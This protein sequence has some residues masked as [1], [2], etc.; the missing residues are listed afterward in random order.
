MRLILLV[1]LCAA[2][3]LADCLVVRVFDPDRLPVAGATAA[4]GS[5]TATS[6]DRGEARLCADDLRNV[7]VRAK[8]FRELR[9]HPAADASSVTAHLEIERRVESAVVV[10]GVIEPT[11]L[12]EVDRTIEVLPVSEP[13][14]PAWSFADVLKQDSSVH[15][16]ERGPDGTQADLSIR[17][18]SF[19]QVLVLVNGVRVNDAQTGHH[20]MDLPLPFEAVEQVEVLHGS[21]ATLYGSDAIGGVINFVTKKPEGR[22]LRLMGGFGD[23][24]WNRLAASGGFTKGVWS[25]SL[26][27]ARDFST[28][29]APGR[30]FRNLAFSSE[31]YFDTSKGSTSILVSAN[32]R[33]FGA[34]GFYGDWDSWEKTGTKLV[35]ASQTL[36]RAG[37][38]QH[39]F[40]FTYRRH[41]DNFILCKFGCVFG[42]VLFAPKDFQNLHQTENYQGSYTAGGSLADRIDW[43]AGGQYLSEGIDSTVAGQR[44]RERTAVYAM[45]NLRPTERLTLSAGVREEAWRRWRAETSPMVSAGYRLAGGFKLRAQAASAFR[46]PTYTDLYHEDPGN[47]GNPNLLPETAWNYEAGADWYSNRGLRV[48]ATWFRRSEDNTIDWVRDAGSSV[49]EARNFQQLDFNGVELQARQ[50]WRAGEAWVNYTALRATRRLPEN[51][52][53]RY[54][55]NFPLNQTTVGYRGHIGGLLLKTEIGA[56]NRTWQSTRALWDVS[57]GRDGG[58]WRPFIQA[59]NLLNTSHEAF[60]GLSQPGRWIRGGVQVQVF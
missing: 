52:V 3:V 12:D 57:I 48:S 23:F 43:S 2:P 34:N 45:L 14:V 1:A 33:P 21:G 20:T 9:L 24:G 46:V 17:G 41:N 26:S 13:D 59:T 38:V 19:D 4:A 44:R 39:R 56:Y 27:V 31:S 49:F 47:I 37:G 58:K 32:D 42:D 11:E 30:D 35:S 16:R 8:G 50:R 6:N 22:E 36:G 40:N 28:G 25:Q 29:F 5:Q 15:L 7:T 51:A 60:Q 55:F 10:T 53:S 54:V 18:S